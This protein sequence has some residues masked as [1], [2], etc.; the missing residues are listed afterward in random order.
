MLNEDLD[1]YKQVFVKRGM[2][3]PTMKEF[4][5][6]RVYL[7][8]NNQRIAN[9]A[10]GYPSVAHLHPD[11]QMK[12]TRTIKMQV[13]IQNLL[14]FAVKEWY[15]EQQI[16]VRRICNEALKAYNNADNVRDQLNA[17]KFIAR[18]GGYI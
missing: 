13:G 9:D 14:K 5:F 3:P 1:Y 7:A 12:Y 18:L 15:D 4:T 11:N 10:A 6:A 16:S 2:C 8:T 17:L